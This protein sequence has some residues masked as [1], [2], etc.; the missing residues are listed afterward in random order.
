MVRWNIFRIT[1][2]LEVSSEKD[3]VETIGLKFIKITQSSEPTS[4]LER[5]KN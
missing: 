3:M 5:F 2:I 4:C 1:K